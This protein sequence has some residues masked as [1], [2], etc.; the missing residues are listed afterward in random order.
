MTHYAPC[1]GCA[2]NQRECRTRAL[3]A[4]AMKEVKRAGG[5]IRLTKIDGKCSARV[6]VFAPGVQVRVRTWIEK[7]FIGPE[8]SEDARAI[9]LWP[10]VVISE[11]VRTRKVIVFVRPGAPSLDGAA[12]PFV[13][14]SGNE[15]FL[16]LAYQH[17]DPIPG[18]P[19][20]DVTECGAC[21]RIPTLLD[22]E[23]GATNDFDRVRCKHVPVHHILEGGLALVGSVWV[24]PDA[25]MEI[26]F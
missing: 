14:K 25:K 18:A 23:C 20:I 22:G 9:H 3:L 24:D 5:T 12:A 13:P 6:S 15:G 11:N 10:G 17:L 21:K 4:D 7:E 1:V 8:E 16:R 26:P 19:R 2:T